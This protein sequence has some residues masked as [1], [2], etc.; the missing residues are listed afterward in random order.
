MGLASK[1]HLC[2]FNPH[3]SAVLLVFSEYFKGCRKHILGCVKVIWEE[4]KGLTLTFPT[5]QKGFIANYSKMQIANINQK[6]RC[7]RV[8]INIIIHREKTGLKTDSLDL[9]LLG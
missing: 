5:K 3:L 1:E 8:S 4:G 9:P 2:L 6:Q 7:H